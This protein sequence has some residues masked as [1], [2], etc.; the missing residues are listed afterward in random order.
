MGLLVL[1]AGNLAV[2]LSSTNW[3]IGSFCCDLS[4]ISSSYQQGDTQGEQRVIG[5]NLLFRDVVSMILTCLLLKKITAINEAMYFCYI[6]I[7]F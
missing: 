1:L 4:V 7:N 5:G 2:N 6:C 3:R